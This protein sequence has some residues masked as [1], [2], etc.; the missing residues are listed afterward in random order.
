[1]PW[2]HLWAW[3]VSA[4]LTLGPLLTDSFGKSETS[5]CWIQSESG[6]SCV[7]LHVDRRGLTAS[8]AKN[9]GYFFCT[10]GYLIAMVYDVFLEPQGA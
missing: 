1:M 10:W 7:N 6:R 2:N 8:K 3:G 4:A 9:N 5:L